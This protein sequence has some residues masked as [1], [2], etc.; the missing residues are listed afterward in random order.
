MADDAAAQG[1][2]QWYWEPWVAPRE[3]H[4]AIRRNPELEASFRSL[5]RYIAPAALDDVRWSDESED[6]DPHASEDAGDHAM[7]VRRYERLVRQRIEFWRDQWLPGEAGQRI[8]H[9][10]LLVHGRA[11]TCLDF[12][13]TFAT[14]CLDMKVPPMLALTWGRTMQRQHAFV[15]AT[16]GR[17]VT[18]E[19]GRV[20]DDADEA[21]D[22]HPVVPGFVSSSADGVL[23]VDDWSAVEQALES[24]VVVAVDF[25]RRP[26]E[27]AVTFEQATDRARDHLREVRARGAGLWLVDVAWLQQNFDELKPLPPPARRAPIRRYMPGGRPAFE[28]YE[29]HAPIVRELQHM[30]GT[31]VL[32]GDSGTGKSTIARE[33][34]YGAQFG[35]AW[36]LNA[37]ESQALINSLD[38]AER[39]E[40]ENT[41]DGL[42]HP[43]RK[44][45]ATSAL[46][47]LSEAQDEWVVVVDNAD[48]DCGELLPWLPQPNPNRPAGVRQLVLITSTN[49]AW[50]QQPFPVRQLCPVEKDE[51]VRFLPGPELAAMVNGRPLLFDAFNRMAAT[52]GWDGARIAEHAP[53]PGAVEP[54]LVGPA[55]LWAAARAAEDFD[56]AALTV[57]AQAAY[58]PPD[59]QPLSV[60]VAL[61]PE[62]DVAAARSL[63]V[64]LGLLSVDVDA[65]VV[66]MHRLFGAAIRADLEM[67]E[68]SVSAGVVTRVPIN[69][70]AAQ[71][72]D[73][74]GDLATITCIEDRLEQ[75]D[76]DGDP[77]A[78]LGTAMHGVATLLE[79]HGH[80]RRSGERYAKAERHLQNAPL[81]LALGLHG[82]ARTV[83]QHDARNEERLRAAL[84]WSRRA[85][86][87]LKDVGSPDR[88]ERC[89]AMQGL[90]MQK[91]AAFPRAGE[92]RIDLLREALVVIERADELRRRRLATVDPGNPH[93]ELLRSRFNRAGIR[94]ELAKAERAEADNHLAI[95]QEVYETVERDRRQIY[96]RDRHPHVAACVIGRAYVAY[97]RALLV[98]RARLEQTA[99]LREATDRTFEALATRQAQEGGIDQDEV[100]KVVRFLTKV[101]LARDVLAMTSGDTSPSSLRAEVDARVEGALKEIVGELAT[102]E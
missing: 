101:A 14:M 60:A 59:R 50:E 5:A 24:G 102:E 57:S 83:N 36:F 32:R 29:T 47:R 1:E 62:I 3:L 31:V 89:L 54:E 97:Y 17:E 46:S 6:E 73:H 26:D 8:R 38:Q 15:I 44:G 75:L 37:S 10:W 92:K 49:P 86:A 70:A 99:L 12:A 52:T 94:I 58:L 9:P 98:S 28:R 80:T 19:D 33:I 22:A 74:D 35:A 21:V 76:E 55:T 43:D 4:G 79:L 69:D 23:R 77:S 40:L 20:D 25:D 42:E 64:G 85:E 67:R 45:F 30:E 16:P 71:L 27:H 72:L 61:A 90:L 100:S 65:E 84:E 2:R 88:A 18:Y 68:P 81:L 63:L 34:A 11:G 78:E 13:T 66:R 95:A 39:L 48:G 51:A 53:A 7:L 91:L 41:A 93:P 96:A 82:R 56:A 87:M